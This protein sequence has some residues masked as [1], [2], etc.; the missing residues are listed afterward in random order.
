LQA[1]Y[2]SA[3]QLSIGWRHLCILECEAFS[4][5]HFG[6]I[7]TWLRSEVKC[8]SLCFISQQKKI[9]AG[10]HNQDLVCKSSAQFRTL[11]GQ[12]FDALLYDV[13]SGLHADALAALSGC[14]KG[15]GI[16]ILYAPPLA[17]WPDFID[18]ELERLLAY[19]QTARQNPGCFLRYLQAKLNASDCLS[20]LS[21]QRERLVINSA[22]NLLTER[23]AL[24]AKTQNDHHLQD[25]EV[26]F[27]CYQPDYSEQL[28]CINNILELHNAAEATLV[29]SAG[30]GRGK[31]A[32]LGISAARW[33]Q[34]RQ[35]SADNPQIWVSAPNRDSV[36]TLFQHA[37]SEWIRLHSDSSVKMHKRLHSQLH[38]LLHS[39][40][41]FMAPDE[42]LQ[43][44][45]HSPATVI[46]P[47]LL[48]VD[49]AASIPLHLLT[50]I[51]SQIKRSVFAATT[52]GYE[53]CGQGFALRFIPA[54]EERLVN[55]R[56]I[57]LKQPIRWLAGDPLE[58]F[59]EHSFL[60]TDG[61]VSQFP[62]K[63][64]PAEHKQLDFESLSMAEYSSEYLLKH[65]DLLCKL[66]KLLI[67]AHYRTTPDDLRTLLD[68]PDV[69][70][71]AASA[72]NH[73]IGCLLLAEETP[74]TEAELRE[75]IWQ[76]KRRPRGHLLQQSF[77]QQLNIEAGL[78]LNMARVIRI[79]VHPNWQRQGIGRWILQQLPEYCHEQ[80][81]LLGASFASEPPVNSFWLSQGYQLVRIGTKRDAFTGS[82]SALLVKAISAEG[83]ALVQ[84]AQKRFSKRLSYFYMLIN[85][86]ADIQS[87]ELLAPHWQLAL[88][89]EEAFPS[90]FKQGKLELKQLP[91]DDDD[92]AELC[93]FAR[94]YRPYAV[95]ADTLYRASGSTQGLLGNATW[96]LCIHHQ[97]S[98]KQ[99]AGQLGLS[100]KKTVVDS[101]REAAAEFLEY[102]AKD[103]NL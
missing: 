54:L 103:P 32:A 94:G 4:A 90:L 65:P 11:L 88:Y 35:Y 102:W 83:K 85:K 34:R 31:S 100:G 22:T 89:L 86:A 91:L 97:L 7:Q 78:E 37:H 72:D 57:H 63:D 101:L 17:C 82:F 92:L 13:F 25:S 14:V 28:S 87:S 1:K 24:P 16:F 79:A 53:G 44:L 42:L 60:L 48:L 95:V 81:V 21:V 74:F 71:F 52:H 51:L 62:T 36:S 55:W 19:P 43:E 98:P 80:T 99:A 49:E 41:I 73:P 46:R 15:G 27:A 61:A 69:R 38:S 70:V 66:F 39:R 50:P 5:A 29:V 45:Q 76:G 77:A 40:L 59:M 75:Q 6:V 18:P 2:I 9:E 26:A 67:M 47:E 58:A 30:R 84:A 33:L 23:L 68:S 96:Q 10:H 64:S 56:H 12:E 8:Q 3:P 93:F 20:R